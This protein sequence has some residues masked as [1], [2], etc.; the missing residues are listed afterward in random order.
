[1]EAEE[2]KR[3]RISFICKLEDGTIYDM[4]DRDTL[5]FTIGQGNTLPSLEMGVLGMKPGEHRTIRVP[6]SEAEEFSFDEDEAPTEGHFPAGTG[7]SEHYGYDFGPG[8]ETGDDVYLTVPS[9]PTRALRE[10]PP[11]GSDLIFEVDLI[12]VEEADLELGA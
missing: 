12:S 1:M 7:G 9:A 3:V 11:A 2:G 6:S 10:R 4:A 5:E 8:D